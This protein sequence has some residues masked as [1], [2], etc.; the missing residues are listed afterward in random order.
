VEIGFQTNGIGSRALLNRRCLLARDFESI[1][2]SGFI[3]AT[4]AIEAGTTM[5]RGKR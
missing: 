2:R 3:S 1:F 4:E 5:M